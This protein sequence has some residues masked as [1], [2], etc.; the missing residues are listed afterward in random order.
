M[1]RKLLIAVIALQ[2]ACLPAQADDL[3]S[4]FAR[5]ED[6]QGAGTGSIFVSGQQPGAVLVKINL[7]GA[8]NKAGI[9]FV[10]P[11]TDFVSL[12][13]YAGG[14]K[15]NAD[16]GDAYI[17]RKSQNKEEIIEVDIR[18][19]MKAKGNH[20]PVLEP[21]DIVVI[22]EQI[23][24]IEPN[25]AVT[26]GFVASILGIILASIAIRDSINKPNP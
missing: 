16:L 4:G 15:S 14:P 17:K 1:L 18:D 22:P 11:Q 20:N 7:W 3:T 2:L 6:L 24:T 10:P 26:V 23:P 25:T 12:L 9:H 5:T 19:I 8:V 13:S 21:N